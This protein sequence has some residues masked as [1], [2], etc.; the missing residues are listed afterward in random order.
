M[1]KLQ[2]VSPGKYELAI[3]VVGF[4]TYIQTVTIVNGDI[5]LHD[6][7]IFPKAIALKEVVIKVNHDR[8]K[9]FALYYE[10]F[11][12]QFLGTSDFAGE[13]KIL[14]PQVLDFD[15]DNDTG[16]L[17]ASS[18][19]FLEIE[20]NALGY[21]ISYQLDSF[22]QSDIKNT[23]HYQG[24]VLFKAMDGT[25]AQRKRWQ[26]KRL[27]A[28][29]GST[30]QFLRA[31]IN[32]NF[33]NE[34][35]K[36]YQIAAYTN[37]ERPADSVI[38]AKLMKFDNRKN[39]GYNADS[40]KYWKKKEKLPKTLQKLM[41]YT[42]N[43]AN[44]LSTTAQPGIFALGCNNDQL[45]I[46]YSKNHRNL[47]IKQFADFNNLYYS[48]ND[49]NNKDLT[50]L[51]FTDPFVLFDSNGWIISS[52]S[53][54][55]NGIWSKNNRVASLLPIDYKPGGQTAI[56]ADSVV[57]NIDNKLQIFTTNH[58]YERVHLHTDRQYYGL[59][60]TLWF[61]AYVVMGGNHQS[62]TLSGVL[63]AELVSPTDTVIQHLTLQL[64]NGIANGDFT[65][66][67]NYKSGTYRLRAFT[68]L[69]LNDSGSFYNQDIIVGGIKQPG[70]DIA[71]KT[72]ANLNGKTNNKIQQKT[73]QTRPDVQ[74]FPEGGEMVNNLRS[75]IAVKVV[76]NNGYARQAK[77]VVIDE[78][79][80]EVAAFETQ[81]A[82][83]GQFA[84][85]PL[86][87]KLYNAKVTYQDG[88]YS[89]VTLPK[90]IDAGF[91][92]TV[93][94]AGDSLYI[95]IAANNLQYNKNQNASFY[96]VAQAGGNIYYTASDKLTG[97][98]FT[99]T[100]SKTRFPSGV[101]QLTLFS[102]TG[103]PLAE[104]LVFIWNNDQLKLELPGIKQS[105][106]P[107]E[108]VNINLD[109][110]NDAG[111]PIAGT[112]SVA[113]TDESQLPVYEEAENTILTDLLITSD[114]KGHI[115]NP[116]YYFINPTGQTRSDLDLLMLT[117]GYRKFEWKKILN[118]VAPK[119]SYQPEKY[120]T[121]AGT[122]N[123]MGGK[124]IPNAQ[125]RLT[126]IKNRFSADTVSD[127]AGHFTFSNVNFADTGKVIINAQKANGGKNVK[128]VITKPQSPP[129]DNPNGISYTDPGIPEK[130]LTTLKKDYVSGQ[131]QKITQLKEVNILSKGKRNE[132]FNPTLSDNMRFSGNL[133][134]PG[135]ADQVFLGEKLIGCTKLSECLIGRLFGVTWRN[136]V[137]YNLRASGHL[138]N[139]PPMSL[140]V[141]GSQRS[142]N[143]LDNINPDDV[144]AIE[145]LTSGG[146][147][148]IYG[149]SAAGGML[150]VTLKRGGGH[151]DTSK[152]VN[153]LVTY[154]LPGYY[155][156]RDFYSPKYDAKNTLDIPDSR[157]T[158]FWDPDV[159]TDA[160]GKATINFFNA[161]SK[162]TYRLVLEGID[163]D[164]NLGRRVLRYK[165]E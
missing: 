142:M 32:N 63:Y 158:I 3:S 41:P 10:R 72:T 124:I 47:N 50:L 104:R 117:Q 57:K 83:M 101:N 159:I 76:D 156:A 149:S 17:N 35:F 27:E 84:I 29:E 162:G 31:A 20:N 42:L 23:M 103:E 153:G 43:S 100:V 97:P 164:G 85:T 70:T 61:K 55:N 145:V 132:F 129:M 98:V 107:K 86:P 125:I 66:P 46:Y 34:G 133:N 56:L 144:Y 148:S 89:T 2:N 39:A 52:K 95:K 116:G 135:H 81:H 93:N 119:D 82:G 59:G 138:S 136:G 151:N 163:E 74:F 92:L 53:I 96:L 9:N 139:T 13:C 8:D 67:A 113:V 99:A 7:V 106:T 21:K 146:N 102:Q 134:G 60:D 64:N 45:L 111:K 91:T 54:T 51:T 122:I 152:T 88:T 121:V 137:P 69:M 75:K 161:N 147:L 87:G 37:P 123:S 160:N 33:D 22:S 120:L 49:G 36:I 78:Q 77:G 157:K 24:P 154:N 79:G 19:D 14:N 114:L 110:K 150:I 118:G 140:I 115:E 165:V 108:S 127:A 26:Q 11:K 141:D 1:F 40:G 109:A 25:P 105:Y 18:A 15:Y 48:L 12:S 90:A 58:P 155:K 16:T 143:D 73:V 4:D 71:I 80:N 112:F 131:Q 44:I 94:N 126:S 38:K 68:N 30:M 28:F 65:L 5:D 128:I 6:I 62:S 130:V